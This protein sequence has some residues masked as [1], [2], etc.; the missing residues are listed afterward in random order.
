MALMLLVT[1]PAGLI[2]AALSLLLLLMRDRVVGLDTQNDY[3][4]PRLKRARLR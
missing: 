1:G 3:Y 4:D 2:G